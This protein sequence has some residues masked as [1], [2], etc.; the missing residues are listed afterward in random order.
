MKIFQKSIREQDNSRQ[1]TVRARSVLF[2]AA[3][4]V[5][6]VLL[7]PNAAFA[8][9]AVLAKGIVIGGV[10]VG[11]MTEDEAKSAVSGKVSEI[12]ATPVTLTVAGNAEETSLGDLGYTWDN[13]DVFDSV[14]D[15]GKCG[16]IISRYKVQKDIENKIEEFDLT[17]AVDTHKTRTVVEEMTKYN[18]DPVEGSIYTTSD[19]TPGVEG[20]TNGVSVNVGESVIKV[21]SAL[22][23]WDGSDLSVDLAY[24]EVQPNVTA[25]TLSKVRDVLGSAATDYSAS[26]WQRA[27]NV[28]N[29]TSKINGTLVWPG[30]EFSVTRAVTPF[31]AENGYE[32]APS[33][34]ENR[35]VD[36]YGGGICQV[37]T[38]LYNAVLKAELQ[39]TARSNHTMRVAYVDL[40]KDA[41]I[42][43]GI[44]DMAF[45]N[46]TDA[47]IYIVGGC[48][49]GTVNFTI[50]GHETRDPRRTIDFE[51]RTI[52]ET[53]PQG[54][55]LFP[56][57]DQPIGYLAQT[58][59]PHTGYYAELWKN[60]YYDGVLQD[61]VKVNS[62]S[63]TPVGTIYSVGVASQYS[64]FTQAMYSA[65]SA[66]SLEQVNSV[67]SQAASY[68][69]E[70]QAQTSAPETTA[71]ETTAPAETTAQAPET[72]APDA[73]AI[74]SSLLPADTAPDG[75]TVDAGSGDMDEVVVG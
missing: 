71:P 19:G 32:P 5:S 53:D 50:Y 25:E 56:D 28:E 24:T 2:L 51:S 33:Y 13:T 49:S 36:S 1:N 11:G 9:D 17:F 42:A 47:P 23:H 65:I 31:T 8:E 41:A 10:D 38:T 37:S 39:V 69:P 60:I 26:S 55:Q 64:W 15:L 68:T 12:Q 62:S 34:E 3:A 43:E 45:V 29:G 14:K 6:A 75:G 4:A 54:A 18:S 20:G 70:T 63:Y 58:Q 7:V 66:N 74:D 72:T 44:M 48:W 46:N 40:S 30:E 35:V 27:T 22:Q 73:S 57:P 52:S 67:I 21:V 61:S 59:S 16:D